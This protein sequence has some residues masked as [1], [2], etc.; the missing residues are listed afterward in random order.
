[1]KIE[2][3]ASEEDVH[4]ARARTFVASLISW[5]LL[6]VITTGWVYLNRPIPLRVV[7]K[8]K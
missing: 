2:Y 6:S 7:K 5:L 8:V 3:I 4:R 1:M